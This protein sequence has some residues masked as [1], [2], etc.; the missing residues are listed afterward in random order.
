[1][2]RFGPVRKSPSKATVVQRP[3][4]ECAGDADYR[5]NQ[6]RAQRAWAQGHRSYWREYRR[7]H[8]PYCEKNREAARQRLRHR[9]RA[10]RFAKMD[11]STPLSRVPSGT[12][13]IVPA[14]AEEFAKMDA[15]IVE[16]TLISNPYEESE[17]GLQKTT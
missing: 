12:Y 2:R 4:S 6:A 17:G 1:V 7:T 14:A 15:W 10:A 3:V 9:R 13:R 8:P 16:M 11:A 5:E